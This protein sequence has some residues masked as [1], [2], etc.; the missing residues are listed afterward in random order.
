M[1]RR[2]RTTRSLAALLLLAALGWLVRSFDLEPLDP[3]TTAPDRAAAARSIPGPESDAGSDRIA[4][5]F[6]Q[7]ESGFM[8]T[9]EGR[10]ERRLADDR[11]G[12]RHQRFLLRL[13][14]GH[15][16]L[17]AHNIDLAERVPVE[18][19][20]RLRLRGQYEWNERGGVLHWTHHDP[21]GRHPGGWIERAGRRFE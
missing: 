9:V 18:H 10:V 5:A 11:D 19:G 1:P 21:D 14:N 12:S 16:L 8:V 4:R 17:V 15:T 2:Q 3:R 20:D 13:A 6:D 7:R